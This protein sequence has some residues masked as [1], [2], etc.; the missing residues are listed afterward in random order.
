MAFFIEQ[1]LSAPSFMPY[2]RL[3]LSLFLLLFFS[4]SPSPS[5]H[6]T[7]RYNMDQVESALVETFGTLYQF[8]CSS[9]SLRNFSIESNFVYSGAAYIGAMVALAF[10]VVSHSHFTMLT[11]LLNLKTIWNHYLAGSSLTSHLLCRRAQVNLQT[12]LYYIYYPRDEW[13]MK[14]TVRIK[15]LFAFNKYSNHYWKVAILW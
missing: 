6:H 9:R 14:L 3:F 7:P 5:R 2:Q 4:R 15:H 11:R 8:R 12:Y 1:S 13:G 10:V